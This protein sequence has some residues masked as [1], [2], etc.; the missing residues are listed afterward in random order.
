MKTLDEVQAKCEV[1]G[2]HWLWSAGTTRK[3]PIIFGPDYTKDPSGS[4]NSPQYGVRAVLHMRTK[5]PIEAGHR[6]YAKCWIPMCIS[7]HCVTAAPMV[8]LGKS[9][10]RS[11]KFKGNLKK[12]AA[13]A[14]RSQKSRKVTDV[15]ARE[16]RMSSESSTALA[17][18]HG[19]N[20][21]TVAKWRSG[22]LGKSSQAGIGMFSGLL[23]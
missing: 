6:A 17:A 3:R 13:S 8:A 14:K 15:M 9:M 21:S 18:R 4:T 5:Q 1:R 11:G 23:R 2:K 22:V 12:C 10:S 7:P 16:F 19:L 20:K